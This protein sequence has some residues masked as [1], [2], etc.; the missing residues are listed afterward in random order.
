MDIN[1][2]ANGSSNWLSSV[3]KLAVSTSSQRLRRT[4]M[5]IAYAMIHE[6]G[7]VLL[8]ASDNVA[9]HPLFL[10]LVREKG[11]DLVHDLDIDAHF[12]DPIDTYFCK[13]FFK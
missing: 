12:Y 9:I 4:I 7:A 11:I 1:A 10:H 8:E 2:S 5:P 3:L 6:E 13:M